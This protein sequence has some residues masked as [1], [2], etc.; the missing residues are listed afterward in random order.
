ML[1]SLVFG[2]LRPC[3]KGCSLGSADACKDVAALI[4]LQCVFFQVGPH[5]GI[6]QA[7]GT[8]G[9]NAPLCLQTNPVAPGLDVAWPKVVTLAASLRGMVRQPGVSL[10]GLF[11]AW[12]RCNGGGE[13]R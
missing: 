2:L 9:A 3:V 8:T 1:L 4:A 10:G 13:L 6:V 5:T 7:C 12:L 11:M